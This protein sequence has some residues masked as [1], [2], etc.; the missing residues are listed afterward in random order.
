[1]NMRT[2][3][4]C[5]DS[6]G[7]GEAWCPT[8]HAPG[9]RTHEDRTTGKPTR[10]TP[11]ALL[12]LIAALAVG[13]GSFLPWVQATAP[14]LG[15]T[16]TQ[17]GIS[18]GDGVVTLAFACAIATFGFVLAR[19][20]AERWIGPALVGLGALVSILAGIGFADIS[21]RF[22]DAHKVVGDNLI[23]DYGLGL[24]V[25]AAGA[26]VAIVAGGFAIRDEVRMAAAWRPRPAPDGVHF[27]ASS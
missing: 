26:L 4:S 23:T 25:V 3:W 5:G 24:W 15:T 16:F 27:H 7:I 9:L 21:S 12:S 8:C 19:G 11:A 14:S 20:T 10:L 2:C 6:C 13:F 1:M 22:A 17:S 18:G